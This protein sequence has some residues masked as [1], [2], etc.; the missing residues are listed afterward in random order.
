MGKF[1]L[2]PLI[3]SLI[4]EHGSSVILKERLLPIKEELAKVEKER[5]DLVAR[6]TDLVEENSNLREQ[7][8]KNN[9]SKEFTEY[10]GALF[11]REVTGIYTPVA[12]CPGCK[13]PLWTSEPEIFPYK[14]S[15]PGCGFKIIIHE[16]LTSIVNKLNKL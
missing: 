3:E 1:K 7:L 6:I 16:S 4:N 8:D 12:F 11:K 13:R 2:F 14:C 10:S 5:A 9:I 15:V